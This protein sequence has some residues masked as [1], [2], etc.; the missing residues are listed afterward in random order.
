MPQPTGP[1]DRP[2]LMERG[3]QV[4]VR[5]ISRDL[6]LDLGQVTKSGTVPFCTAPHR[7]AP[8]TYSVPHARCNLD[9]SMESDVQLGGEAG[10]E[11]ARE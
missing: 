11:G 10:K 3:L 4:E 5:V 7:T 2:P 9:Q 1:Q 6:D 8:Y